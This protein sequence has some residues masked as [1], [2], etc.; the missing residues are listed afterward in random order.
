MLYRIVRP[1]KRKGSQNVQFRQRIPQDVLQKARGKTLSIP[2]G[3]EVVTKRLSEKADSVVI[4]LKTSNPSEAKTRHA[5]VV[6]YLEGVWESLRNGP[7]TLTHKQAVALSGDVFKMFLGAIENDPGTPE[8]WEHVI[9]LNNEAVEG[10]YGQHPLTIPTSQTAIDSLEKRFGEFVD[11]LL[12]KRSLEIDQESRIKVLKQTA[13]AMTDTA[14]Q[15]KRFAQGDYSDTEGALSRFP[16]WDSAA[17]FR[18]VSRPA[19]SL[20]DLLNGWWDEAKAAERSVSTMEGYRRTMKYFADF[21][22][23]D[24]A[25]KV[26]PQDVLNFKDH[27]LKSTNPKTGKPVSPKT[28]KDCDL[29]GLKSVFGWALNNHKIDSNPAL[30]ITVTVPKRKKLREKYFKQ[31]EQRA[32]LRAALEYKRGKAE[33]RKTALAKRWVPWICAY[34][35]ARVGEI[36]QLRKED[37]LFDEGH[38]VIR[39]TPDAGTVKDGE[40]RLVPIHE[41]LERF[42]FIP[43]HIQRL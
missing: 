29:A 5:E 26:T 6:A 30:G 43:V 40:F 16:D 38:W 1:M 7:V 15:A 31:H 39:I 36:A 18:T 20:M 17:P 34:T 28:V 13:Q 21:L 22:G 35:G 23:H 24:D 14:V 12:S 42:P 9:A 32:I 37:V 10:K 11:V 25:T 4:S 3:N 27:R 33:A 41:H 2:I 19:I 8:I